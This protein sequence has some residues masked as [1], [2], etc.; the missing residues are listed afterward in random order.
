MTSHMPGGSYRPFPRGQPSRSQ[1]FPDPF[2]SHRH[3]PFSAFQFTDP[4]ALFDSIFEGTPFSSR[5]RHPY[6]AH[7]M[8]PFERV[9]RMQAE[10]EGFM[11]D[12]DRDPFGFGGFPR[13]G[14]SPMHSFPALEPSSVDRGR[15]VSESYMTSTVNGVTQTIRKRVDSDVSLV[16]SRFS[17]FAHDN[18]FTGE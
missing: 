18:S 11:D 17:S 13:F 8:D 12:I 3:S 15:W 4:F 9:N 16:P 1:T 14:F 7:R 2:F 10:I 6:Y 5:S